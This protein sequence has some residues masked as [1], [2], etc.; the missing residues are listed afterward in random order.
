[1]PNKLHEKAIKAVLIAHAIPFART[2]NITI[3]IVLLPRNISLPSEVEA[4]AILT[5]YAG[6]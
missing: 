5:D 2:G 1:M 4:S 3:L 6:L